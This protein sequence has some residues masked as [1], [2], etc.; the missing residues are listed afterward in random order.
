MIS[1]LDCIQGFRGYSRVHRFGV[2]V[3]GFL[4]LWFYSAAPDRGTNQGR[5]P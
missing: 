3:L 4:S 2:E 5:L 1:F